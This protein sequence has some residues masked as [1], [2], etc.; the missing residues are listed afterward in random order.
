MIGQMLISLL[1][2]RRIRGR[3]AIAIFRECGP[4]QKSTLVCSKQALILWTATIHTA[5]PGAHSVSG[6]PKHNAAR[7]TDYGFRAR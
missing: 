6:V 3:V 7:D 4:N 1:D 2:R 5:G